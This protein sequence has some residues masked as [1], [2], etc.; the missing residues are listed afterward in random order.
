MAADAE[1]P[2]LA[3]PAEGVPPVAADSAQLQETIDSLAA[4]TGPLAIDTERAHGFRYSSRAYLIQLRRAGSGT[5]LVDP[6]RFWN[7]EE[8]ADLSALGAVVADAVARV[9]TDDPDEALRRL[10]GGEFSVLRGVVAGAAR[11]GRVIVLDGLATSIAALAA[12]RAEPWI[13]AHLVAGQ[14]SREPAHRAVLDE[15]GVEPLLDLR[16]RSGE[17]VGAALAVG[18]LRDALMLRRDV[19]TTR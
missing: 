12:V 13:Q 19:A 9:C 18:L 8:P 17:G 15:L 14:C 11:V 2:L 5:H 7:D 4:G 16:I 3:A 6:I 1:L 10:G